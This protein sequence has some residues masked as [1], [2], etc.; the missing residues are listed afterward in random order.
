MHILKIYILSLQKKPHKKPAKTKLE[1][2]LERWR[3]TFPVLVIQFDISKYNE[4][5]PYQFKDRS[6]I[7]F[8]LP[9]LLS[10]PSEMEEGVFRHTCCVVLLHQCFRC[11]GKSKSLERLPKFSSPLFLPRIYSLK[12]PRFVSAFKLIF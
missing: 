9:A 10:C 3:R 6:N 7:H 8:K 1:S 11:N 12:I 4:K 2:W 5:N